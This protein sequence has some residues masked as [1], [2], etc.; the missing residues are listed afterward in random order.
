MQS[1]SQPSKAPQK[2]KKSGAPKNNQRRKGSAPVPSKLRGLPQDSLEVRV[3]KT[4]SYILRH[5]AQNEGVPMRTDG[6]VNVTNLLE[7]PRLKAQSVDLPMLQ[8]IVRADAKQRFD[9]ICELDPTSN[10][11]VWWIRANQ[12]HTM[13][14]VKLELKPVLSVSDIPSGVAIHGTDI[15]AWEIISTEGLSKMKRNHIHLAQGRDAVSGMRKTSKVIIY[16]DVQKALDADIK[17]FLS[18]NGVVL[19][20]G[21]ERGSLPVRFFSK[22]EDANGVPLQGWPVTA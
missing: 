4:L 2:D 22:V 13:K 1:S 20:E 6:Y 12:G 9:L 11:S 10:E 15:R 17:F 7:I 18:D 19:T 16:I 8:S 5:G 14:T 3:S 21:D